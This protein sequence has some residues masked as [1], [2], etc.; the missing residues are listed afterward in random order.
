[1]KSLLVFRFSAFLTGLFA[2]SA[3]LRRGY[4]LAAADLNG[5]FACAPRGGCFFVGAALAGC[6]CACGMVSLADQEIPGRLV[7]QIPVSISQL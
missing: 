6:R 2:G 4:R 5:A 7:R 1:L 3:E